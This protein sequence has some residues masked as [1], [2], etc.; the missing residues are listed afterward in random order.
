[1]APVPSTRIRTIDNP[2]VHRVSQDQFIFAHP[3]LA[4]ELETMPPQAWI[5]AAHLVAMCEHDAVIRMLPVG[6]RKDRLENS[7]PERY[8]VL[9]EIFNQFALGQRRFAV[10][11]R[12]TSQYD[13]PGTPLTPE[14]FYVFHPPPRAAATS[15]Q[16]TLSSAARSNGAS[17]T[18]HSH[19]HRSAKAGIVGAMVGKHAHLLER[20]FV[21][22]VEADISARQQALNKTHKNNSNSAK[23]RSRKAKHTSS[24]PFASI[25]TV[26][27]ESTPSNTSTTDAVAVAPSS[28]PITST[29]TSVAST[30]AAV[31][32]IPLAS[33]SVAES[34]QGDGTVD[35][36]D[37]MP[38]EDP[39]MFDTYMV[40]APDAS[41]G[42]EASTAL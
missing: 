10:W 41:S 32:S 9:A 27:D 18:K 28:E 19:N 20:L 1:M 14:D 24:G 37:V 42:A 40:D 26:A 25:E 33:S 5:S 16:A 4:N 22:S 36:Q 29:S 6:A 23:R 21:Q 7:E 35:P 34:S 3:D 2:A 13:L 8:L 15:R 12:K 11:N 31:A 30:S 39:V 17:H 38:Y